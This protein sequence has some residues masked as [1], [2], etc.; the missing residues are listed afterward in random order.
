MDG[1]LSN[2]VLHFVDDENRLI[3]E[4]SRVT[5]PGGRA[6]IASARPVMDVELLLD[7]MEKELREDADSRALR[8]F[9]TFAAVNRSLKGG[10]RNA[11]EPEELSEMLEQSGCWKTLEAT[12]SY[13]EQD[14]FVVAARL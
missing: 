12:T 13:L 5:R 1:Y 14:F 9:A 11:H 6:S 7:A 4:M 10:L 3:R 2:N 8:D